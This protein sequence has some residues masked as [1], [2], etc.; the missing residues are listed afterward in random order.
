VSR[1]TALNLKYTRKYFHKLLLNSFHRISHLANHKMTSPNPSQP[2][3]HSPTLYFAYGSNLSLAQMASRCPNSK[4]H[5]FGVLKNYKWVIG[6][7]GYA[8]VVLSPPPSPSSPTQ[9]TNSQ[10]SETKKESEE[11]KEDLVYGLLYTLTPHDEA[12]LDIA[13]GVPRCYV[14]KYLPVQLVASPG[15]QVDEGEV[16]ALVYVDVQ[17]PGTG[18]C[19]EEY[20]ARM[21]RGIRDAVAKGMPREYVRDVMRKWVREEGVEEEGTEVEDPFHPE[22][23]VREGLS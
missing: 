11:G 23:V 13:E 22:R 7:R 8:N 9:T 18:I 5:S 1:L 17:R 10:A 16:T 3:A 12:A 15:S 20:V 2:S 21:N 4:Y 19:K 6:P 14:K